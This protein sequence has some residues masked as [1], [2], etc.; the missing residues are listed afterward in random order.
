M[1]GDGTSTFKGVIDPNSQEKH[2]ELLV[3]RM[4]TIKQYNQLY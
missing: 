2:P 4:V 3:R 1:G